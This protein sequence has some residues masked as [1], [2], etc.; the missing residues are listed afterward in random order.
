MSILLQFCFLLRLFCCLQGIRMMTPPPPPPP[1]QISSSLENENGIEIEN[2]KNYKK[3]KIE[4][5][6]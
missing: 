4:N 3:A 5:E 2:V 1:V 6:R